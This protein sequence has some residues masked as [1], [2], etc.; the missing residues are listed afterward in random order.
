VVT[1]ENKSGRIESK[2]ES[3]GLKADEAAVKG[4]PTLY[5]LAVGVN[6]YHDVRFKLRY[7]IPD[8]EA[9]S[10]ALSEAGSGYYRSKPQVTMLSDDEV[11]AEKL[12]AVFTE[13]GGKI[14]ATDVFLFFIA[15]HGATIK[16][17]YHFLPS[18]VSTFDEDTILM[19]GIGKGQWRDW[20]AKI[21]AQKSI[22]IFDTC[23]SGSAA[24]VLAGLPPSVRSGR[25]EFDTAQQRLKE[26]TGRSLFTA[27]SDEQSA[28]E[29]FRNHGLLTY[30]ILEGLAKAGGDKPLIWL[31]DLKDYVE[32]KVRTYSKEMKSCSVIRQQEYCQQPKVLLGEH[33]YAL[34]P[35]YEKILSMLEADGPIYSR[36]PTHVVI[37]SADLIES[38]TRGAS[39]K[40]QLPP[41]TTV[42]IIKREGEYAYVAK[43][44]KPL[45]YVL[46]NKLVKLN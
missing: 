6:A 27:S 36:I 21:A 8:A 45:G 15:G 1:A 26:A 32:E 40:S 20:F 5:V 2:S 44:G 31:T 39:N 24:Q 33:N 11:T 46:F 13:L 28:M 29:G 10:E 7:A 34:V 35:R 9:L 4:I 30:A 14:R 16:G 37:S 12:E 23:D 22:F 17:N 38:M 3:V 43:D 18:S 42:T 19:Q 41:G 25:A